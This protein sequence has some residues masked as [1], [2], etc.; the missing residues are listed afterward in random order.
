MS[1]DVDIGTSFAPR[2]PEVL[3]GTAADLQRN[4]QV[5]FVSPGAGGVEHVAGEVTGLRHSP[6]RSTVALLVDN[7]VHFVPARQSVVIIRMLPLRAS[8]GSGR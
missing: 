4:D 7:R 3:R 8:A 2:A 5:A 6:D 1:V